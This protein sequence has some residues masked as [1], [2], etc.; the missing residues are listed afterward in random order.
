MFSIIVYLFKVY[1]WEYWKYYYRRCY[2]YLNDYIVRL[3]FKYYIKD[4]FF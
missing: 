4:L 3:F 1:G 2:S